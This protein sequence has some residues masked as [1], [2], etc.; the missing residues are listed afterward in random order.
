MTIAGIADIVSP[1]ARLSAHPRNGNAMSA[2][3][4]A[5]LRSFVKRTA[6]IGA[7]L[8]AAGAVHANENYPSRPIKLL[9]GYAAGGGTDVTARIIAKQLSTTLGQ[10]VIVENRTGAAGTIA[11]NAVAK[12]APDGYTLLLSAGSDVTITKLTIKD[13]P[14]NIFHDFAPIARVAQ[15]P[16]ALVMN[17]DVPARTVQ[18]LVDYGRKQPQRL[19][20]AASATYA[21]LTGSLFQTQTRLDISMVPYKGAAP[22][23]ADLVGGH[24]QFGFETLAVALPMSKGDKIKILAVASP[25]RS[26]LVPNVPTMIESGLPGF[27][28]SVWYGMLAPRGTPAPITNKLLAA[29]GNVLKSPEFQQRMQDNGFEPFIG[30]S[31]QAF[32]RFMKSETDRWIDVANRVGYKP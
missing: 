2:G 27:T 24:I 15:T 7:L 31:P 30:D 11:A 18:E 13:L 6:A 14:Y 28:S 21:Q 19:N 26:S 9:V 29:L 4:D 5:A 3:V 25:E 32:E 10:P 23:L 8:L 16:F 22:A 17:K 12:A 1:K 20:M